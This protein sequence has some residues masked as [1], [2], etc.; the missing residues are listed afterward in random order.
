MAGSPDSGVSLAALVGQAGAPISAE[1]RYQ[2]KGQNHPYG[3]HACAV[4]VDTETGEIEITRYVAVDDSGRLINPMIVEGQILGGI[5]QGVSHALAEE[6]KFDE[7]GQMLNG[8]LASYPLPTIGNAIDVDRSRTEAAS[9]TN[10]LGVKGVG[11]SGITGATAAVANAVYAALA[12][13]GIDEESLPMP[14][15]PD[16]V[17][18]AVARARGEV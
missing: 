1:Q 5:L 12:P 10:P 18:A 6:A 15:T 16:K 14:F 2:G 7:W 4:R 8:S 3:T 17:W 9:P 13:L 11:E